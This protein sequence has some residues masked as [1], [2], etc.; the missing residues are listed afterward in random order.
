MEV[1]TNTA[2]L[3]AYPSII[4]LLATIS[5]VLGCGVMPNCQARTRTFNVT[6]LTTLRVAMAYSSA[7]DVQA[8][9]PGIASN[10]RA[11]QTFAQRLLMQTI[12][13]V[14]E[15]KTHS[16]LIPDAVISTIFE[17]TRNQNQL[18]T[19]ATPGSPSRHDYDEQ[20]VS[21]IEHRFGRL[22][23]EI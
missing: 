18:Q 13:D 2:S 4:P 3:P 23:A 10:K 22:Q 8:Q 20:Y 15:S 16:T 7:L 9:V 21:N 6:G 11:A 17:S 14:L 5:T 12:F 1:L 19:T